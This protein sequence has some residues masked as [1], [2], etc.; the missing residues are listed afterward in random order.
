MRLIRYAALLLSISCCFIAT[1]AQENK[2]LFVK[3]IFEVLQTRDKT[4]YLKLFPDLATF[5][6]IIGEMATKIETGDAKDINQRLEEVKDWTQED[7]DKEL[8]TEM[9]EGFDKR[10]QGAEK[11]GVDWAT[12]RMTSWVEDKAN[13]DEDITKAGF[14][15]LEGKIF[16]TSKGKEFSIKFKESLW[17]PADNRWYGVQFGF[18]KEKGKEGEMSEEEM[19]EFGMN[20]N[21][22]DTMAVA[23]DTVAAPVPPKPKKD[24]PKKTVPGKTTKPAPVKSA[25]Q[26][27]N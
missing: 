5:K 19:D 1:H 13:D 12:A 6:K 18:A 4:S 7:F 11:Q 26:K 9:K 17:Y 2:D 23:V 22:A 10:I 21:A 25:M 14:K 15:L 24:I 27:N 16:F 3:K 8:M 20:D